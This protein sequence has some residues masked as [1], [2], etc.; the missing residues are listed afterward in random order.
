MGSGYN[1]SLTGFSGTANI[2]SGVVYLRSANGLG[3]GGINDW[4]RSE[5]VAVDFQHHD[6]F[7]PHHA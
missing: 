4:Q 7:Q 3:S 2:Q 6:L 1:T 5:L